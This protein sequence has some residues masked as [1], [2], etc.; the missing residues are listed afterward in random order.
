MPHLSPEELIDVAER[1]TPRS[2]FPHLA[3]CAA[4]DRQVAD[5]QAA[6]AAAVDVDVPEPSPLFWEHLS[7]RVREAVAAEATGRAAG[8]S[9]WW[10]WRV[11][12][13][14][15]AAAVLMV[16]IA[17]TLQLEDSP[18]PAALVAE[19]SAPAADELAAFDDDAALTVLAAL[20][21]E[22]DWEAAA[23]AGLV[24]APG[25]V[26]R[27]MLALDADER[28]ELHRILEEALSASGA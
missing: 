16:M 10:S 2:A 15:A 27:I 6:M 4:C 26:E 3:S 18:A 11:A 9:S 19:D 24:A 28:L 22:L 25:A 12:A 7:A 13:M 5:L 1:A 23:E 20:T 14:T 8:T 17:T 21:S